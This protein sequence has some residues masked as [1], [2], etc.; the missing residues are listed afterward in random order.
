VL[1]P[2]LEEADD[3][4]IVERVEDQAAVSARAH[5]AH[6]PKETQLVGYRRFGEVEASGEIL[7]TQLRVRQRIQHAHAR[8]I[9]KRAE[10][11]SQR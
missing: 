5:Q 11:F 7:N 3:V 8:Q 9:A 10:G 6:V 1:E 2:L 4:L